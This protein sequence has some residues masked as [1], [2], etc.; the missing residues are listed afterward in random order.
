MARLRG[1]VLAPA[2]SQATES[3]KEA[4]VPVGPMEELLTREPLQ[5]RMMVEGT[6]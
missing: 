6:S 3:D 5:Q 4:T 1:A 2:L